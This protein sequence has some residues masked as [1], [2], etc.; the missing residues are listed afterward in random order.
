MFSTA[1]RG[2]SHGAQQKEVLLLNPIPLEDDSVKL[3]IP[4]MLR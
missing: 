4:F 3:G 1:I 2:Y